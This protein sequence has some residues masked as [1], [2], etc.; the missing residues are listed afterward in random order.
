M[1][2]QQTYDVVF[3]GG[4]LSAI[5]ASRFLKK[6]HPEL[7]ILLLDRKLETSYN[8]GESTVGVTGLF[9][10]R[11]LGLSTY[12]YV[13]HLP[14]NGLRYFF[15]KE[16]EE[17][18]VLDHSEI[19][20]NILPI[21]PTFQIDRKR[22]D[23]DLW[24]LNEELGID[25]KLGATLEAIE[26][27]PPHEL[28]YELN[29]KRHLV[30]ANWLVQ[31]TGRNINSVP[32]LAESYPVHQEDDLK[33][34]AAW[35]RYKKVQDIDSL[36]DENWM[37]RVG[38]TSRYLST[39]HFMGQGYWIWVIPIGY[40]VVSFGVVYDTEVVKEDLTDNHTFNKFMEEHPFCK[41]LLEGSEQLDFQKADSVPYHRD[42]F[43]DE[44]QWVLLAE[45]YSFVDPFYSPGSDVI[46]RQS[47]L[48][49]HLI[50]AQKSELKERV[51]LIN[52]YT[53][54]ERKVIKL[55]YAGQY[56]GFGS[57]ELFNIKSLWDFHSYTNRMVWNFLAKR[58]DDLEWLKREVEAGERTL[59]LTSAIQNGFQSLC[60]YLQENGLYERMNKG[61]YSLRQ[62][63]FRIE[64]EM[65]L[66]FSEDDSLQEHLHLCKLT[67]CELLEARFGLSIKERKIIQDELNF[68]VMSSFELTE[69]W[70]ESFLR[71]IERRLAQHVFRARKEKIQI[72]LGLEMLQQEQGPRYEGTNEE[73]KS[74]IQQAWDA[75]ASNRV[76][77]QLVQVVA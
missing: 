44:K 77:E 54:F 27:G 45:S 55:L 75:K 24:T 37:R 40:D 35:G 60:D 18:E 63:R 39:N 34:A 23:E 76:M 32:E 46:S 10:I 62:N 58:F 38:F 43:C 71:R 22:F 48:L 68:A 3:V 66:D 69:K 72:E 33:T 16:G 36:G 8:P 15:H 11:D 74:L 57:F 49:D 20:S 29:G 30:Q 5:L 1:E 14:K 67:I 56:K 61:K 70:F 28:V 17:L 47:Y 64:E 73:I 19:G 13:N 31:A 2:S 7:S 42:R 4:G 9:L 12:C 52:A 51:D 41:L 50:T 59:A 53:E 65:L 21:F 26:L 6:R 25:L